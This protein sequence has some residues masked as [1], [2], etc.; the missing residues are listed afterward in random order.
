M[1]ESEIYFQ[2]FLKK[3]LEKE[4]FLKILQYSQENI[5]VGVNL[6]AGLQACN[7]TKKRFQHTCFL[8]ILRS[9]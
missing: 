5:C 9:F 8:R 3:L 6:F 2:Q 1:K 7:F 4:L